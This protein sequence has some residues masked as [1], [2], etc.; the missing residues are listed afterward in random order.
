MSERIPRDPPVYKLRDY[1]GEKIEGT[2]Y[3]PELQKII[4]GN[5]R[6]FK[7]EKILSEKIQN[8]KKVCLVKW[9]GWPE[10]FNSWVPAEDVVNMEL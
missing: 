9:V 5:D 2:F 1:D 3:E 6:S 7:I 8:R 4:I 10:K